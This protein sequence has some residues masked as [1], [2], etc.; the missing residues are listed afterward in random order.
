MV[1]WTE[2]SN[3]CCVF[4][5]VRLSE[6]HTTVCDNGSFLLLCLSELPKDCVSFMLICNSAVQVQ[7]IYANC[8]RRFEI[9]TN[10]RVVSNISSSRKLFLTPQDRINHFHR[11]VILLLPE[12]D[13]SISWA[14][15]AIWSSI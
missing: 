6:Y 13:G 10:L 15:N 12:K 9:F 7:N 3:N 4:G 5:V 1:F 8:F 11:L 2:G 14:K